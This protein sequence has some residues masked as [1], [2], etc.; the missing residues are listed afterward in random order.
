M[1]KPKDDSHF[2]W[3]DPLTRMRPTYTPQ[4]FTVTLKFMPYTREAEAA[5][6]NAVE[7]LKQMP[8]Y[9]E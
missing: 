6:R 7:K 4:A 5:I 9:V 3:R 2:D 8:G 1:T